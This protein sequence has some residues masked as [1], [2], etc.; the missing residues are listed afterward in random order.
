M[1]ADSVMPIMQP[2]PT[3]TKERLARDIDALAT[4]RNDPELTP[5]IRKA[6]E[7][8]YDDYESPLATPCIQLVIDFRT[9]GYEGMAQKAMDG[10]WDATKDEA[11][12]WANKQTDPEILEALQLLV[13][14]DEAE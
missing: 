14:S 12:A 8:Y 3:S 9:M 11:E 7:G 2:Q 6:R 5:M 10:R 1:N 13:G 4:A